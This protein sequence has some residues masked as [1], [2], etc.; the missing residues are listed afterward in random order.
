M[1][2]FIYI[3]IAAGAVLIVYNITMLEPDNLF[4]GKSAVA[5]IGIL[6]GLCTILLLVILKISQSISKKNK[7]KKD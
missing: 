5:A 6:A 1:K 3:L 4:E 7:G 2:F